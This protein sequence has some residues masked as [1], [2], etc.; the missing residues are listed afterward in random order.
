LK[1]WLLLTLE[2]APPAS[3][4]FGA[5]D[6]CDPA[7]TFDFEHGLPPSQIALAWVLHNPAITSPIV[8]ATKLHH[9]EDAVAALSVR[10]SDKEIGRL[11]ELYQPHPVTEAF[12]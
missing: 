10:L 6:L 4:N 3:S 1:S 12:V 8:G 7:N 9:L 5:G 11:E 2:P